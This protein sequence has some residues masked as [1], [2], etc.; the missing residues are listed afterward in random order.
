M[1]KLL[2]LAFV[3]GT[4]MMTSCKKDWTCECKDGST[5]LGTFEITNKTKATAKTAC[6]GNNATFKAVYP[7]VSCNLK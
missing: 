3:A 1:K 5:S 4:F 7:G 6:E 2:L